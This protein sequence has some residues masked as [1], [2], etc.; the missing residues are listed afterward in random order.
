MNLVLKRLTAAAAAL[1]LCGAAA[2]LPA[3]AEEA[4]NTFTDQVITYEKISGG[5][6]IVSADTAVTEVNVMKEI[7]G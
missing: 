2:C 4:D 3:A 7:D 6:R 5:V 1:L